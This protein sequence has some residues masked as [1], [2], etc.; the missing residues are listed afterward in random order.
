MDID[1]VKV[2]ANWICVEYDNSNRFFKLKDGDELLIDTSYEPERHAQCIGTVMVVCEHLTFN[3]NSTSSYPFDV[4]VEVK[5]GD[6]VVFHYLSISQAVKEGKTFVQGGKMY[7]FL[8]YERLFFAVRGDR[9][10]PVNGYI[11]V[12]P[13]MEKQD[14]GF[15][16]A[17]ELSEKISQTKG[18]V[19][20][21]GSPIRGYAGDMKHL[22]HLGEDPNVAVG[23]NILFSSVDAV[24]LQYEMHSVLEKGLY[25]MQRKDVLAIIEN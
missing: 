15:L 18:V 9:V 13:D 14:L 20:H 24:P 6:K 21:A 16:H 11:F 19:T 2:P 7:A 3:K 25:R 17:T 4:D 10:I 8:P 23:D 12:R 5:K 1:K 22:A